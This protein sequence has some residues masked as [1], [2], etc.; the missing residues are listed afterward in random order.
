MITRTE[1]PKLHFL[2]ILDLL[3]IAVAPL[4]WHIGVCIGVYQNVECTVTIELWE[5]CDRGRDLPEDRLD[6]FLDLLFGLLRLWFCTSVSLSAGSNM[7][8][9]AVVYAHSGAAFSLSTGFFE[10]FDFDG[11]LKI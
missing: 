2:P 6:F 11:L 7:E 8:V 1:A 3:R 10:D 5:E 9:P 4:H